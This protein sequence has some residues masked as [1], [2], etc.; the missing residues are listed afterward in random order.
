MRLVKH[1]LEDKGGAIHAIEPDKPVLDAIRLMA[2]KYIGALLVMR[3]SQLL[4]IVSERDYARKVILKGRSSAD[5]PVREIMSAQVLTVAP[6]D[7]V[8]HCMQLV[9]DKRVRHLPVVDDGR[10]IGVVSIGDLVK[11]VIEDQARELE[12]MQRYIA[13]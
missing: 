2:D 5:T 4:G 11:A 8:N 6:G 13:G 9:T 7:S 1:L 10:V 3:G 12:H